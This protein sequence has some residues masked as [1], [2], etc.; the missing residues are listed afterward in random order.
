MSILSIDYA[1]EPLLAPLNAEQRTAVLATEGAVLVLAGAGSGK[2]RVITHRI[3]WLLHQH[4]V[5][6]WQ[7]L[8][9]TF[10]NKAAREMS[11]RVA[12]ATGS[13]GREVWLGTFHS[14]GVRLLRQLAGWAGLQPTFSI[15]DTDDQNR[16][17]AKICKAQNI[18]ESHYKPKQFAS[19]I[20]RAKNRC[21]GPTD[22]RLHEQA[23]GIFEKKGL[24]VY[25]QYERDMRLANAVDFGD[26]IMLPTQVLATQP[27]VCTNLARRFRYVLVDEFQDTNF[28]QFELLKYLTSVHGNLCVVG[29]DDQSIYSW[30]G[31]EVGNILSFPQMFADTTVVKLERNYRST[32]TILKASTAVVQGNRNRHGK[33]LWTDAGE[34]ELIT[35]AALATDRDEADWVARTI[36]VLRDSTPLNQIAVFYRT[37]ACSRVLEDSMRRFRLPYV[38]LGGMK[39]YERAEVKDALAWCRLLVNEDDSAAFLRAVTNPKRGVGDTTLDAVQAHANRALL[40]VPAAARDL[41][42]QG[43]LGRSREKVAEFFRI[44]A[45]MRDGID[46]LRANEMGERVLQLSG[47]RKALQE[48]GSPEAQDRL[49]NLQQLLVGMSEHADSADEPTLR[50]YLENVALVSDVDNLTAAKERLALMTMHSAK[51]LEFDVTFVV[52]VEEGLCPHANVI[53]ETARDGRDLEEERRLFYVAMTR[54]RR[55]M[56]LSYAKM[57][58]RY[59]GLD[60]PCTPSRFLQQVP[61]E[62]VHVVQVPGWRQ[63]TPWG[64]GSSPS[65]APWAAQ[66]NGAVRAGAWATATQPGQAQPSRP[67]PNQMLSA[68]G[69][70]D[71]VPVIDRSSGDAKLQRGGRASHSRFG[72]GMVM[73]VAGYGGDALV[74]ISFVDFGVKK[75]V[76]RFLKPS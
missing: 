58:R 39:F 25:A 47:L 34:G 23:L 20:D 62:L 3:A 66:P 74:T 54:A 26:L 71:D 43:E 1:D 12:H 4:G 52:G 60:M 53:N 2:T 9:M 17:L 29:D 72:V 50:S 51:G 14:V 68:S 49:E 67:Q 15:Y 22:P 38:L 69:G 27:D 6:P 37:N 44:V 21:L 16:L 18:P 13:G 64:G 63:A 76:A 61:R 8:A 56:H 59:D 5:P 70:L 41:L 7:V 24:Q 30:R 48:D 55:K 45:S 36:E 31:A 40:S 73:D 65:R 57:R 11:E 46:H 19:Y 33:V 35:L 10:T 28:A 42:R 75:V 32:S